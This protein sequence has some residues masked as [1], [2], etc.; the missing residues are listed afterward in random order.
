[1]TQTIWS[2]RMTRSV[3]S[4]SNDERSE[5][6]ISVSVVRMPINTVTRYTR[7][8]TEVAGNRVNAYVAVAIG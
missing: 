7:P 1:M 4:L 3:N 6:F 5:R 8:F 2:D